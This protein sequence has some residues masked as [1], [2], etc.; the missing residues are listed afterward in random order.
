LPEFW[1]PYGNLEVPLYIK[2]EQ[3]GQSID[4]NLENYVENNYQK[5]ISKTIVDN[6]TLIV[7]DKLNNSSKKILQLLINNNPKNR[8]FNIG[9]TNK[10]YRNEIKNA[11]NQVNINVLAINNEVEHFGTIDKYDIKLSSHFKKFTNNILISEIGFDPLFGFSG[12]STNIVKMFSDLAKHAFLIRENNIP[13]PGSDNNINRFAEQIGELLD[14]FSS[15]E[16]FEHENNIKKL[17][18][19]NL[20]QTHNAAKG[21]L[22]DIGNKAIEYPINNIILSP[23]NNQDRTLNSSINSLFNIL[24]GIE[25]NSKITLVAQCENGLGSRAWD[26]YA[27]GRLN[28]QKLIKNNNYVE[29][30]ESIIYFEEI[31]KNNKI[32]LV[33]TLPNYYIENILKVNSRKTVT[34]AVNSFVNSQKKIYLLKNSDHIIIK[35]SV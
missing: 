32:S 23:G 28:I 1:I 18:T 14:N 6:N 15:I 10:K 17:F 19:G 24:H 27:T 16:I 22:S 30:L 7:L 9:I 11:F 13:K 20:N 5:Q 26:L 21:F 2:S 34:E 33:S 12:G 25:I 31:R 3:F 8:I 29:G 4:I 35:K